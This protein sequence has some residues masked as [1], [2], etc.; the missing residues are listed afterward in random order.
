MGSWLPRDKDGRREDTC[1]G[2][3][4]E[5]LAMMIWLSTLIV[6]VV[7]GSYTFDN[8]VKGNTNTHPYA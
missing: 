8:V 6:V 2:G 1:K 3:A 5:S 7:P 4:L